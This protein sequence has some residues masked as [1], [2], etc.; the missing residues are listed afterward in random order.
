MPMQ[1]SLDELL[2]VLVSHTQE[3]AIDNENIKNKFNI[4]SRILYKK[5]LFNEHDAL[6]AIRDENKMLLELG[7]IKTMP[8]EKTLKNAAENLMMWI[9]GDTKAIK[10]S[11][12]EMQKKIQEEE[13]KQ[14][15]PRI[16][17]APAGVL[18]QLDRLNSNNNKKLI[19]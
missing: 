14:N 10:R 15:A 11:L 16:E 7:M 17:T 1:I 4:M 12:E 5:G 9:K 8:D 18:D 2:G 6:E 3:L 19:L 13:A